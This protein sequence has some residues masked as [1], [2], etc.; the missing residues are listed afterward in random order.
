MVDRLLVATE[1][2]FSLI[3]LIVSLALTVTV[4]AV[5]F[6]A[7]YPAHGAFATEP[8]VADVQQRLRVAASMLARE[9][10]TGGTG[11]DVHARS[12]DSAARIPAVLPYRLGP[13]KADAPGTTRSDVITVLGVP[14]FAVATTISDPIRAPAAMTVVEDVSGCPLTG[15][16]RDP[17][18]GFRVGSTVLLSDAA[19]GW[20]VFTV[21]AVSGNQLFLRLVRGVLSRVYESGSRIVEIRITTYY[22]KSDEVSGTYQLMRYNGAGSD[23]AVADNVVALEFEYFGD[24]VG[25][26][27]LEQVPITAAELVAD[28]TRR[29]R[30]IRTRVRAE[31]AVAALRGPVGP[32]FAHGGSGHRPMQWVPDVEVQF[33][34]ALR[35]A[36]LWP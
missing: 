15:R 29:V 6:S 8:E 13:L 17:A 7:V 10:A 12:Q 20:D 34:V 3:E 4:M 18:C 27:Q 33:D 32:L 5:V 36:D 14:P 19:G 31:A 35:N 9:L 25:A 30:R 24:R 26:G 2:G 16:A 28:P 23:A 21:S 22:L 11:S 1:S